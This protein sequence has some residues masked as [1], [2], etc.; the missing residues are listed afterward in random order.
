MAWEKRLPGKRVAILAE[1]LYEDLELW[2]PSLIRLL[3]IHRN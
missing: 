1:D 2:Y 3:K